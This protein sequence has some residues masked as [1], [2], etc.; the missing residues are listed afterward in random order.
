MLDEMVEPSKQISRSTLS[1]YCMTPEA[2]LYITA[3]P[4]AF[5]FDGPRGVASLHCFVVSARGL[6]MKGRIGFN[7]D[8]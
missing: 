6:Y 1:L 7:S 4:R 3:Q 8:D 5:H 2:E